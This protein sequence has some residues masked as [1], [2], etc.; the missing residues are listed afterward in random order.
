MSKTDLMTTTAPKAVTLTT[1]A[2]KEAGL[3]RLSVLRHDIGAEF[4]PAVQAQVPPQRKVH[5]A[6]LDGTATGQQVNGWWYYKRSDV[7]MIAGQLGIVPVEPA[8]PAAKPRR[9]NRHTEHAVA[10]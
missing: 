8:A 4:G 9:A 1:T 5:E 10:A 2:L 7:R 3:C 6:F